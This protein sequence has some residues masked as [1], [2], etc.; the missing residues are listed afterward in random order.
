MATLYITS[1]E[2]KS[3]QEYSGLTGTANAFKLT[4]EVRISINRSPFAL[5][6]MDE[7]IFVSAQ[8]SYSFEK[9][10]VLLFSNEIEPDFYI[11]STE[12]NS[13]DIILTANTESSA[14]V[15]VTDVDGREITSGELAGLVHVENTAN[16]DRDVTLRL[17]GSTLALITEATYEIPSNNTGTNMVIDYVVPNNAPIPA[18]EAVYLTCEADGGDCTILGSH[19]ASRITLVRKNF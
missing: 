11:R 9:D 1:A 8:F 12:T 18:G 3:G 16:Q 10:T 7:K 14:V 13:N 4:E 6:P 5:Y 2:V 17:Y 19:S 15:T